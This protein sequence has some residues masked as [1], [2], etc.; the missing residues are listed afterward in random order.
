MR[1]R[2]RRLPDRA[3]EDAGARDV[4]TAG[5]RPGQSRQ[6]DL[7]IHLPE[8][9]ERQG[10]LPVPERRG[11][12]AAPERHVQGARETVH[13]RRR[14]N[15]TQFGRVGHHP[16]AHVVSAGQATRVHHGHLRRLSGRLQGG[17]HCDV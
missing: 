3:P 6:H 4:V 2:Q 7:P 13:A 12:R 1:R 10:T 17:N 15:R 9:A 16:R 14:D 8:A 11:R 5:R